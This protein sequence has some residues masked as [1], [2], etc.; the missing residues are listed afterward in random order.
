MEPKENP[1]T[2]FQFSIAWQ[3]PMNNWFTPHMRNEMQTIAD[4]L[5]LESTNKLMLENL[6]RMDQQ[7]TGAQDQ[8]VLEHIM[9]AYLRWKT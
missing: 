7:V 2:R 1:E 9:Q 3:Q 5:Y 8:P 4:R 6:E